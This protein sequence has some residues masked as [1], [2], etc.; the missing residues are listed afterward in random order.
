MDDPRTHVRGLRRILLWL[1][2][3]PLLGQAFVPNKGQMDIGLGYQF[4]NVR[5]HAYTHGEQADRGHIRNQAV[6]ADVT[7][8]LT[9]RMAL[10]VSLPLIMGKYV[11]AF[12]HPT[13]LD[14]GKYHA[15]FAD[16]NVNLRYNLIHKPLVLTPEF[17]VIL[18]S[19]TYTTYAHSAPGRD[20]RAYRVGMNVAR[21]LDP[22]LP[23][24]VIQGRYSYSFVQ[25]L[26]NIPH[27]ESNAAWEFDY[28]L[29]SRLT[30]LGLGTWQHIHGGVETFVDVPNSVTFPPE[31]VAHHDRLL[32]T[33]HLDLGGGLAVSVR[34]SITLY[35]TAI[36]SVR[37]ENGHRTYLG[38]S[39]GVS[40]TFKPGRDRLSLTSSRTPGR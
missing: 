12:P 3:L 15:T 13:S 5:D 16:F 14:N 17:T 35:A 36:T 7:F 2:P 27:N 34:E 22:I 10:S 40:Y 26:F 25:T 24:A 37:Y 18:P 32:A 28:F 30:L 19:H 38:L 1:A 8:G 20:L 11:G 39:T 29:G 23:K 6:N 9:Q 4:I 31:Q 33:R 21:R